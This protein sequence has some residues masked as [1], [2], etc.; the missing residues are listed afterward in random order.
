[1]SLK[2]CLDDGTLL[3]N[4]DLEAETLS[5]DADYKTK[6]LAP[7]HADTV[8]L[9]VVVKLQAGPRKQYREGEWAGTKRS[10]R[11][12][13]GFSLQICPS[14]PNLSIRYKA[15]FQL[16]KDTDFVSDGEFLSAGDEP[17]RLEGV[18]IE[19]TGLAADQYDV[20]YMAHLQDWEDTEIC[21]NGQF[22]G[23]RKLSKRVEAIRV[24][25]ARRVGEQ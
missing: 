21:K 22:C 24:W 17:R 23:T 20:L 13:E 19:L 18:S 12:L 8:G 11:Y 2:F 10:S 14:I 25:I 9:Q 4:A 7:D 3:L 15:H 16:I 5:L 1:M 6:P